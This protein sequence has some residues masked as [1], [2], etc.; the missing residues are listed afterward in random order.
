[1]CTLDQWNLWSMTRGVNISI[2]D[3]VVVEQIIPYPLTSFTELDVHHWATQL[4]RFN[5]CKNR[6]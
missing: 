1:L 3:M 5:Y 2:G 6:R 4:R